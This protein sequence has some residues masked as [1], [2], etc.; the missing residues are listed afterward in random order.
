[1]SM[2]FNEKI[3]V[4]APS[5]IPVLQ[6][7][8][9]QPYKQMPKLIQSGRKPLHMKGG[10]ERRLGNIGTS[11][12]AK[13]LQDNYFTSSNL[14]VRNTN[15]DVVVAT[16]E[17]NEFARQVALSLNENST[18]NDR[19]SLVEYNGMN[20]DNLYDAVKEGG[21]HVVIS[22]SKVKNLQNDGYAEPRVRAHVWR[23]AFA[24]GDKDLDKEYGKLVNTITKRGFEKNR[25]LWMPGYEGGR[26]VSFGSVGFNRSDAYC[27][28][29][30]N[31][32]GV[33]VGVGDGVASAG[34]AD[35]RDKVIVAPTLEQIM[36]ITHDRSLSGEEQDL[37]I[38]NL[39]KQ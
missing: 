20:S 2:T 34:G 12:D 1:M 5:E 37:R 26:L 35:A 18:I 21:A 8:E 13:T 36:A 23:N 4:V 24:E 6:T 29:L 27:D 3:F 17:N 30:P 38:A 11:E 7:F 39:Y 22:A 9:G 28:L 19:G 16:Y 32:S 10:M 31:S 14:M 25:G 15:G 33:L